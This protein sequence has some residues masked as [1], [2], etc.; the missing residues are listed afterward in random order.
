MPQPNHRRSPT[1]WWRYFLSYRQPRY[2]HRPRCSHPPRCNPQPRCSHPPRC[3]PQPRYNHRPRC[4]LPPR[5]S[6]P[7]RYSHRPRYNRRPRCSRPPRCSRRPRCSH[8]PT[9]PARHLVLVGCR[10]GCRSPSKS[11]RP[12]WPHPTTT[13]HHQDPQR[14]TDRRPPDH[15]RPS[16]LTCE[17]APGSGNSSHWSHPA[18]PC[19]PRRDRSTRSH[20][21]DR[22]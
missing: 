1:C 11:N 15:I 17:P 2:N 3:N 6:R 19:R 4:N 13:C 16:V 20:T 12:T 5:C 14:S 18:P 10:P 7:P 21:G 9:P 22:S 8:C